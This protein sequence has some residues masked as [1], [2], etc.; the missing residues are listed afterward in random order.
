MNLPIVKFDSF[1]NSLLIRK[2]I[3]DY[4]ASSKEPLNTLRE[5]AS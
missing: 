1:S 5:G 2:L 4:S 3:R